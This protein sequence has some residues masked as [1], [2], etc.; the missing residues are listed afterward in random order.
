MDLGDI[1]IK[2]IITEKSMNEAGKGKF[3]FMVQ[4]QANK[5]MIKNKV[6]EKFKVN[7]VSVSSSITKGK[8]K[9]VGTRRVEVSQPSF[10]KAVVKLKPGQKIDLFEAGGK[11]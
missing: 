1:I 11:S 10:K 8:K 5:K 9:K 4:K 6:E 7:V 3:T 2:P